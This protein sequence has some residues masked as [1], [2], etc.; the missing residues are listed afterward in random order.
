MLTCTCKHRCMPCCP[1]S[2]CLHGWISPLY[3]NQPNNQPT[4]PP[5]NQSTNQSC[6]QSISRSII[7]SSFQA[8]THSTT[9]QVAMLSC[10]CRGHRH[11]A[12]LATMQ[13]Q[14]KASSP[15]ATSTVSTPSSASREAGG[16]SDSI[17][18]CL[19][20]PLAQLAGQDHPQS[21][22]ALDT[23]PVQLGSS[24][25]GRSPNAAV[26]KGMQAL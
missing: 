9:A 3:C 2:A 18:R 6:N 15:A 4:N 10:H 11:K 26:Q 1:G 16:S 24:F 21:E 13:Q 7:H 17:A 5:T 19:P 23:R 20:S 8:I 22:T 14:D 25:Q 12:Q